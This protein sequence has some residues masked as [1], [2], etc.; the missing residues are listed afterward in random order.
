M[1]QTRDHLRLAIACFL[2]LE[3]LAALPLILSLFQ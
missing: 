1:I 3:L 2:S